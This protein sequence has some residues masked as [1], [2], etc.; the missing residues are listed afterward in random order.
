MKRVWF[1]MMLAAACVGIIPAQAMPERLDMPTAVAKQA[2]E[3]TAHAETMAALDELNGKWDVAMSR[4]HYYWFLADEE[5]EYVYPDGYRLAD[6]FVDEL[7]ARVHFYYDRHHWDD[8]AY[9]WQQLKGLAQTI[10]KEMPQAKKDQNERRL[11][12][13]SLQTA[14]AGTDDVNL[15]YFMEE[16]VWF[17]AKS[18]KRNWDRK[19]G[20]TYSKSVFK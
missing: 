2:V 14:L 18:A 9:G 20:K 8:N 15:Q 10:R 7:E 13:T 5:K 3:K 12:E 1:G 4:H 17:A 11:I 16:A 6:T 19:Y